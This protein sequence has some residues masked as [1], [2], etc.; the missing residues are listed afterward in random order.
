[1]EILDYC[2]TEVTHL[3]SAAHTGQ[4]GSN[5][6]FESKVF[7]AGM[8]DQV[9][10]EIADIAQVSVMIFQKLIRKPHLWQQNYE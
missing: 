4:E 6:D 5:L 3:L 10:M 1:M 9:A 2:E 7:H 8:I